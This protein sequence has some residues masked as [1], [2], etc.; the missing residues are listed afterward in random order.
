VCVGG[1]ARVARFSQGAFGPSTLHTK[2]LLGA[3]QR[4]A[5]SHFTSL[6]RGRERGGGRGRA[7]L[8]LPGGDG[9]LFQVG[10]PGGL[11][12]GRGGVGGR[13]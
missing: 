4:A 7:S 1:G 8:V 12:V 11:I 9:R 2:H 10:V 3:H 6:G 5:V 13:G